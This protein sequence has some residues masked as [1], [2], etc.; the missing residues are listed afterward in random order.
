MM[1]TKTIIL[2]TIFDFL[3]LFCFTCY[4]SGAVVSPALYGQKEGVVIIYV[5]NSGG[6]IVITGNGFIISPEGVVATHRDLISKLHETP[7]NILIARTHNNI[8]FQMNDLIPFGADNEIALVRT[9][10]KDLPTVRLTTAYRPEAGDTVYVIGSPEGHKITVSEGSI[11]TALS[12]DE[13]VRITPHLPRGSVG[14]P[15]LNAGGEV[16]GIAAARN[17]KSYALRILPYQAEM[18]IGISY[19]SSE[20]H[21]P[22]IQAFKRALRIKPDYADAYNGLGISYAKT[23]RYHEAVEAFENAS[24]LDPD[25][26]KPYGNL[27]IVYDILGMHDEALEAYAKAVSINPDYAEAHNGLG[28]YYA[29]SGEYRMA[30]EAFTTAVSAKPDYEE[31][32]SNLAAV[33]SIEGKQE[34]AMETYERIVRINPANSEARLNLAMGHLKFGDEDSAFLQYEMLKEQNAEMAQQLYRAF[35]TLGI[36]VPDEPEHEEQ[37]E[38]ERHSGYENASEEE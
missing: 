17:G 12:K 29:R 24:R 36:A 25:Y 38:S 9:S 22:A 23:E 7:G 21:Q 33:C 11:Q 6:K 14:S 19:A 8:F 27:G 3:L 37:L 2:G 13:P 28:V 34:M 1:R 15:V 20:Q 4:S 5:Q 18:Y 26:A 31:A 32:F 10:G 35:E 30:I 16:F